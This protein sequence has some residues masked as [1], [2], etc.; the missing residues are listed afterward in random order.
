MEISSK[1]TPP[2]QRCQ[3]HVGAGLQRAASTAYNCLQLNAY[4]CL[5]A[6]ICPM[7][8]VMAESS[9]NWCPQ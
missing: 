7:H 5:Q 8:L 6:N 2:A 3:R 1:V 4:N 9:W